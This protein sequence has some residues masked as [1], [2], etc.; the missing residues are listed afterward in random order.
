MLFRSWASVGVNRVNAEK[1]SN[2]KQPVNRSNPTALNC[3]EITAYV[4]G[5]K[6]VWEYLPQSHSL[7]LVADGDNRRLIAGTAS[8]SQEFV[9][10]APYSVVFVADTG[11][12]PEGAQRLVLAAFDAGIACENL[13]LACSALGLATVPRA[14]MNVEAVSRLLGLDDKQIP[15]LNNP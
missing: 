10:D 2:G 13:T 6:G 15:M 7:R 11:N 4:F 3:Q 5:E 9:L 1:P 8:F 12:L 14:T